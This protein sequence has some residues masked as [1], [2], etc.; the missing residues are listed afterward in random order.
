MYAIRFRIRNTDSGKVIVGYLLFAAR[1]WIPIELNPDMDPAFFPSG[2]GSTNS[3]IPVL[4]WIW[5]RN[6]TLVD[7]L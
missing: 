3:L 4:M 5:I 7:N 2:S 1:L 6:G